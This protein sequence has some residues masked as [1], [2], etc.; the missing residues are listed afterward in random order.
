VRRTGHSSNG[1]AFTLLEG[2]VLVIIIA[3]LVAI[4][5]PAFTGVI[6]DELGMTRVLSNAKQIQMALKAYAEDHDGQFPA[7]KLSSNEAYQQLM[8][9]YLVSKKL[10]YISRSAWSPVR[11]PDDDPT[12]HSLKPGQNHFAYVPGLSVDSNPN[13]PVVAEGFVEGN[14]G[15]YSNDPEAKGGRMK[16]KAAIVVRVDGSG[17]VERVNQADFR[18]YD[19]SVRFFKRDLF[20]IAPDWLA[21]DQVPLNPAGE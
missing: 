21:P 17:R 5:L 1:H 14:P 3:L 18:V 16:G 11:P 15:V 6:G 8:P 9:H 19:S 7:A 10:C 13:F 12:P 20:A 4:S 2:A